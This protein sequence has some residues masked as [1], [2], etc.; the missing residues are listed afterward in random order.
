MSPVHFLLQQSLFER[1][2]MSQS[3]SPNNLNLSNPQVPPQPPPPKKRARF[4]ILI[5]LFILILFFNGNAI[6]QTIFALLGIGTFGPIFDKT[7]EKCDVLIEGFLKWFRNPQNHVGFLNGWFK[8][9]NRRYFIEVVAIIVLLAMT[10]LRPLCYGD[11]W[12]CQ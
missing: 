3:P 11:G 4:F 9:N 6:I 10:T 7:L 12:Q 1:T 8:K 2:H 5:S